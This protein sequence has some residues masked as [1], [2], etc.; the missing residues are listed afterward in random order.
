VT[1]TWPVSDAST[2]APK[3]ICVSSGRGLA[4]HLGGVVHFD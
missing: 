2:V 3:M 4:D 1:H